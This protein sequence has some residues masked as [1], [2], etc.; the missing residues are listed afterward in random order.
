MVRVIL[1]ENTLGKQ[2]ITGL[3]LEHIVRAIIWRRA[4]VYSDCNHFMYVMEFFF[5]LE[6][7][8]KFTLRSRS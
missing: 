3:I 6:A 8:I 1:L 5:D 4:F 7:L 2:G